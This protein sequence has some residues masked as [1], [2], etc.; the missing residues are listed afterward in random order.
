[1]AVS[2]Q[3]V[4]PQ[5]ATIIQDNTLERIFKDSLFPRLLYRMEV[6][7]D[8]WAANIGERMSFTKAGRLTVNTTPL[9]PGSDPTPSAYQFEQWVAE[10]AQYGNTLD[11]HM[12]TSAV[13]LAPKVVK[14]A[15][16]LGLN[17]GET[18]NILVRDRLFRAYLGG[19]TVTFAAASLGDTQIQVA[20]LNGFTES[21]LNGVPVAVN[22]GAPI[23]VTFGG[24]SPPAANTVIAATPND[25][26]VPFGPGVL[27]L[28]AALSANLG[29]RVAVWAGTRS[30]I[31]RVGNGESV[32]AITGTNIMTLQ[33]IIN[34]VAALRSNN[35]PP[36][37]SGYYHCHL[38]TSAMSQL[39][40]DAAWQTLHTAL[41]DS[42][43]YKDLVI[44]TMAKCYH[45]E[46][47]ESPNSSNSGTLTSSGAGSSFVSSNIGGE[48]INNTGIEIARCIITGAG[49]IYE[50]YIDESAYMSEAGTTGKIGK[51]SVT[52]NG[53]Q[54]MTERIRYIM[55]APLDRL[56][57]TVAQTWSW[58]GDFPVPSD[59]LTGSSARY[60]RAIILEHAA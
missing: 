16:Q 48:L 26:N 29:A 43:P 2:L 51:F 22:S 47:T 15:Q 50:K 46:N 45:Y 9:T 17:A 28:G 3:S 13:A 41:P 36:H 34:A 56:Q 30:N 24:V 52:N 4:N 54:I 14:D 39:Y 1:M 57:Q 58:S 6:Q 20:S 44:G 60:K 55:R 12:P 53:V 5:L 25:P 23:N 11:T 33:T 27:T 31:I 49:S 21:L 40:Q 59:V 37:P 38:N 18:L 19:N 7:A 10:A 8:K 35:V 42:V 32:D